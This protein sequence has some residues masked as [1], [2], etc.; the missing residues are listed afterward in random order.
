MKNY[1]H[2]DHKNNWKDTHVEEHWDKVADVYISENEKVKSTHDQRFTESLKYLELSETSLILNISSRDCEADDYIKNAF[3][4]VSIVNAEISQG[5]I[6]IAK[7]VRPQAK[8]IKI[9]TYSKLPFK[10]AEFDR[11]ICLETL[12]HVS[13][14][15]QFLN[16]LYR[17]S[18]DKAI[19]VLSCPPLTSEIPYRVYTAL[20]GGHGEGPHRFLPSSEVKAMLDK[21]GWR[22]TFHK[23]TLLVPAGPKFI[24]K[25]GENIIQKFQNT[26]ISEFGIRQFYVCEKYS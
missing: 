8:Q 20:F 2:L 12:E 1:Q 5:L 3:P 22:L 10:E 21:T 4:E 7:K 16:E 9:S 6:D 26:F 25:F 19:M 13:D 11:I 24:Q 15:L 23:G 18:T 14:P 17:V